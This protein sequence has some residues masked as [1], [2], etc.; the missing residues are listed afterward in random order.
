MCLHFSS[1]QHFLF[2]EVSVTTQ[3]K[4]KNGILC[5]SR[6]V[7]VG[8]RLSVRATVSRGYFHIVAISKDTF[9]LGCPN[10]DRIITG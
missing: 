2:L 6:H 8:V 4:D 10:H 7:G 3:N 1:K 9:S 5:M